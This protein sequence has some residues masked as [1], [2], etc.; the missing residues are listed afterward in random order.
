MTLSMVSAI[1]FKKLWAGVLGAG[2]VA[3]TQ[4]LGVWDKAILIGVGV[5]ALR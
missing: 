5:G 3:G 2:H 4:G 1:S